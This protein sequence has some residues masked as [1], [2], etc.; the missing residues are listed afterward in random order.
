MA[1]VTMTL[2]EYEALRAMIAMPMTPG[3]SEPAPTPKK[4]SRAARSSDKKLSLAFREANKRLRLKSG[5]LR[6]GKTQADV[7]R[8]AQKLRKK[9]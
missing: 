1:D 9:M 2:E 8:L 6:S 5:A 7:A 4:R 3:S